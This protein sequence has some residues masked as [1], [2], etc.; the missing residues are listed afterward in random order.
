MKLMDEQTHTMIFDKRISVNFPP[1]FQKTESVLNDSDE[2]AL[3]LK[4]NYTTSRGSFQEVK[5]GFIVSDVKS[6][7]P[8]PVL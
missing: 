3:S 5:N 6:S 1:P 2:F 4:E 7:V 8:F